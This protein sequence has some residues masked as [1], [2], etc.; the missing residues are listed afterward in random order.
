MHDMPLS[1]D[2]IAA[3]R[4]A[5]VHSPARAQLLLDIL[6]TAPQAVKRKP[7]RYGPLGFLLLGKAP[8]PIDQRRLCERFADEW[9]RGEFGVA[10][11][12]D[13]LEAAIGELNKRPQ[14]ARRHRAGW[15]TLAGRP[16]AP[17]ALIRPSDRY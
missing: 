2:A 15:R 11:L 14:D 17:D 5:A 8:L 1:E 10:E 12:A 4:A 3:V 6:R 7:D 13:A 16:H 9:L